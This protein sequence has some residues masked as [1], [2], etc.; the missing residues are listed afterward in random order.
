MKKG[1]KR[2]VFVLPAFLVCALG[3]LFF[4]WKM[5]EANLC[6]EVIAGDAQKSLTYRGRNYEY[7]DRYINIVCMGIDK[8]EQ[9]AVRNDVGNSIGQADAIFLL[10]IDLKKKD[11]RVI[12]IPRD[13]M[14]PLQ[15]FD[16]EGRY[17]GSRQGQLTL[18]YAFGDGQEKSAK[19]TSSQVSYLLNEIPI[20]AYA[21]INVHSLWMLNDA[22]GGVDMYMDEDYTA[23]NPAFVKGESVHLTGNLLENYIRER[24]TEVA[25]SAFTRIDRLKKYMLAFFEQAK[26]AVKEDMMLPIQLMDELSKD[27]ETDLTAEE[28][29]YLVTKAMSCNFSEESMYT[30]PGEQVMG[31]RYEEY[32][33][34]EDALAAMLAELFYKAEP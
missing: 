8:E 15:M 27:M 4:Y 12:A 34:D 21:A 17:T 7:D 1:K 14:V 5:G 24:D 25:G 20:H 29:T 22:V 3:A 16:A 23:C 30:L 32:H 28:V 18:Q 31:E 33:I 19:L 9:M 10:S 26:I 2:W 13:T 11:I 6:S